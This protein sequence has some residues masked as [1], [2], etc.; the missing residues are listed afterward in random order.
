MTESGDTSLTNR[1][2]RENLDQ[3]FTL[4]RMHL[5]FVLDINTDDV[6]SSTDKPKQFKWGFHKKT[7]STSQNNSQQIFVVSNVKSS[8]DNLTITE[9]GISK[10]YELMDYLIKEE[11][12]TQEG[13]FR[14]TGSLSRQQELKQLL[15]SASNMNLDE[16]KYS[17]HDCASVLKGFL[18]DLSEPLLMEQHYQTYCYL[19]A[20]CPLSEDTT[21][22][23]FLTA[24]Q[25]LLL[26]LPPLH[27]AFLQRLLRLLDTTARHEAHN[28]M[29]PTT[30][31]T[32]FTPHLL[33]P[34][35]LPPEVLH[36]DAVALAPVVSFMIRYSDA[37]FETPTKLATDI[38]AYLTAREKKR[39]M[40]PEIDL[41]E[42]ITDR[43]AANTVYTFVDRQRT[44]VEN[45]ANPTDT[46]LAQLYAHIQT[47]PDSQHK[48]RL[49]KQF[50]RQNGYGTPRQLQRSQKTIS[51]K[52]FG[53]SIRKH[54]FNKGILNK[55]PKRSSG[56]NAFPTIE[57]K[58]TSN[59]KDE[60]TNEISHRSIVLKNLANQMTTMDQ[61]E[62]Q[63]LAN[64]DSDSD[65][66]NGSTLSESGLESKTPRVSP[67]F[68]S[69]PNL[70]II[71]SKMEDVTPK[72][73][74]KRS[75]RMFRSNFL[76]S[77]QSLSKKNLIKKDTTS[78]KS[79]TT[80]DNVQENSLNI[81][82][83]S[84]VS[85]TD[86][87]D[88]CSEAEVSEKTPELKG[89]EL[90]RQSTISRRESMKYVQYRLFNTPKPQI[91]TVKSTDTVK[92][93]N[94]H[95]LT[96]KLQYL[97]STPGI[98]TASI[99]SDEE[100]VCSTPFYQGSLRRTSMSPITKSTQKLSKAMQESIMTPRSRKPLIITS[101]QRDNSILESN[102]KENI[103]SPGS[104]YTSLSPKNDS[105]FV[106]SDESA[107][108]HNKTSLCSDQQSTQEEVPYLCLSNEREDSCSKTSDIVQ[109]TDNV[110]T[111]SLTE[112]FKEYLLSRSVLTASPVDLSFMAKTNDIM[113]IPANELNSSLMLCLDGHIPSPSLENVSSQSKED[114]SM[115]KSLNSSLN[116][117]SSGSR[118]SC[119]PN[120]KRTA[121][122]ISNGNNEAI[123]SSEVESKVMK[124]GNTV[125]NSHLNLSEPWETEL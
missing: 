59:T 60:S 51:T 8:H 73:K 17:V 20:Q 56:Q 27:R 115:L 36:S 48:R 52:S 4:V 28:R 118:N 18:A 29:S 121:L 7:K 25:L 124:N 112:P 49:V 78:S 15:M 5:S 94:L 63:Y 53:E 23:R 83:K 90:S 101:E 44:W 116:V 110:D 9:D 33:C 119:S 1:L 114:E 55:T 66:S 96:S 100:V 111:K 22:T 81:I 50:N 40:S 104:P 107:G 43:T 26:L 76:T 89:G 105:D 71:E 34:R 24:L 64:E 57:E 88:S 80:S 72:R 120:R 16:G 74:T 54:I 12:V 117:S 69:E 92:T 11:N 82:Y 113:N 123:G 84:C 30:L 21:S 125:G 2:R 103:P 97:T 35:R 3:Y 93:P 109:L 91:S 13:I 47:L 70:S 102:D 31:A 10:V 87:Q 106:S 45:E 68:A 19:S 122:S 14:R 65:T 99:N 37:V 95:N 6:D 98:L 46:A 39:L 42:S 61:N 79:I 85:C 86:D 67:K 32:M 58:L 108:R 75:S 77:T 41:D 38:A 62:D